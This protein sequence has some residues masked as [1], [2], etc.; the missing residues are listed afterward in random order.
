M[1]YVGH[2]PSVGIIRS[3]VD[4]TLGTAEQTGV[5]PDQSSS[6]AI[7]PSRTASGRPILMIDPH[8]PAQGMFSFYEFHLHAGRLQVGGFAVFGLPFAALG[9]TNGVAWAG[10]AGGADSADAFEL[11]INPDNE[12]Q[13]RYD[14][15]WRD[16]V[17]CEVMLPVKLESGEVETR[18]LVLRE[19]LHG[20]IV[21]EDDGRVFAGAVCGWKDTELV[22]QWLAMNR[23]S[24][25]DDLMRAV[26][27]DQATWLNFM[28]ATREGRIGYIQTGSCPLRTDRYIPFGVQDGTTSESNWQGRVAFDQLPQLH[29]PRTGWLQNCNTAANVVTEGMTM[30]PDEFSPGVL[31]GH[32]PIGDQIWRG[33]MRRC[34]E[35]LPTFRKATLDDAEKLALDTHCPGAAIWVTPLVEAFDAQRGTFADPAY[36]L[37]MAVDALRTWDYRVEKESVAATVFRFWRSEYRKLRPASLGDR[38]ATAYP[39]TKVEQADAI[40]A[41]QAACQYLKEHHG[42]TLVP[43]GD[44][45]RLR[46]GGLDLPLDGDALPESETMRSTGNSNLTNDGHCVFNGGQVVTTVVELTDPIQV[47]SIVPYGQS[48]KPESHHYTDQMR[49]YSD[50]KLR[51]AWHGWQQVR[52]HVESVE[53]VEYLS[54]NVQESDP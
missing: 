39:S 33:R 27:K 6:F 52:Q 23:A 12:N 11:T 9:Y 5:T 38:Q 25:R 14:G 34:F 26:S 50:G 30:S 32:V 3:E 16:M 35:V 22:E 37:K 10:T 20:P 46:R 53:S 4:A 31:F 47:R 21:R 43:W 18:K 19:T 54:N 45:M 15:R 17:V 40:K 8:W 51:P 29:D 13:Y 41:L 42:S 1:K 48:S 28:Y 44:V 7:G 36:D 24:T 2:M 49:C